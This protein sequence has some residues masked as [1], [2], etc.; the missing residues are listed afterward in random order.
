M[1]RTGELYTG[2]TVDVDRRISEHNR[3][4]GSK[5][6]CSRRPVVLA[7]LESCSG[8]SAALRRENA[9][10]RMSRSEKVSLIAG[11]PKSGHTARASKE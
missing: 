10:K 1:C 3:G 8:R 6:T 5:F 7:Y 4:V 2:C 9:I 11:I